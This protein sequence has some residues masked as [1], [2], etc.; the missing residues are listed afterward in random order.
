MV[1]LLKNQHVSQ[2]RNYLEEQY[3][4][5]VLLFGEIEHLEE[6]F[7]LK[8]SK[9]SV[10]VR[11]GNMVGDSMG[12]PNSFWNFYHDGKYIGKALIQFQAP[13]VN[14]CAPTLVM[15][16]VFP[17]FRS[18]GFGGQM[19]QGI[20][21]YMQNHNFQKMRLENTKAV[22]F[23]RNLGYDIDIDEGEKILASLDCED[24]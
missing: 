10:S 23:W 4:D 11:T 19:V 5:E 1:R 24:G 18:Q 7:K 8:K 16:E 6:E 20:E 12:E 21:C 15:F 17:N 22:P 2:L 9:I 3:T 14:E 13:E